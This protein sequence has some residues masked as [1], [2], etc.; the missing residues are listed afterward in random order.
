[1]ARPGWTSPPGARPSPTASRATRGTARRWRRCWP[2]PLSC[3]APRARRSGVRIGVNGTSTTVKRTNPGGEMMGIDHE[4]TLYDR[5]L[6]HF[7]VLVMHVTF[8]P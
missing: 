6:L 1:M 3:A 5:P 8:D 2:P 4:A 7:D